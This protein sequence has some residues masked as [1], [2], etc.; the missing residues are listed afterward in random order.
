MQLEHFFPYRLAVAAENFSRA[1]AQ[2]YGAAH[3]L[4]RD[5]WRILAALDQAGRVSSVDIARRTTLDKVQVCRAAARMEE[6]GLI[7]RDTSDADRRLREF[8]LT[9]AGAALFARAFP[10]VQARADQMLADF[11]PAERQILDRALLT[12]AAQIPPDQGQD[13]D[14]PENPE[15]DAC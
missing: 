14:P 4:S 5:E 12:L 11:T 10:Q 13:Q 2:V 15:H 1:L 3:G 8:A 9:P 6:K 7:S